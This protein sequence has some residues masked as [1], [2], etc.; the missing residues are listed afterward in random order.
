MKIATGGGACLLFIALWAGCVFLSA[1]VIELLWNWL[2][3]TLFHGPIVTY[4]EALGIL[5]LLSIVGGLFK[6]GSK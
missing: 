5:V 4:W 3:P 2:I 1:W 6:G